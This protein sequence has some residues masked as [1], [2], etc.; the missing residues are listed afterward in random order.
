VHLGII[1]FTD[2]NHLE[3]FVKVSKSITKNVAEKS[4]LSN[5]Y[6][7]GVKFATLIYNLPESTGYSELHCKCKSILA[8]LK[9]HSHLTNYLVNF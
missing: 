8:T 4:Q 1:I 5:L 3:C 9:Q 6:N 2:I 7:I